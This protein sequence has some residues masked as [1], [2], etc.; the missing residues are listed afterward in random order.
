MSRDDSIA[1]EIIALETA[2]L[3]RWSHGD[4]F[5]FVELSA[6]DIVYFDPFVDHRIDG[7]QALR[8]YYE[9]QKDHIVI[10]RFEILNPTVKHIGDISIL[11]LNFISHS[12]EYVFSWNCS[13][14]FQKL[15]GEWRIIHSHWSFTTPHEGEV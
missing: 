14:V 13:E 2:A 5:G 4:P 3:Q 11:A 1:Q 12:A 8:A 7:V 10:D 6:P 9:T 15:D